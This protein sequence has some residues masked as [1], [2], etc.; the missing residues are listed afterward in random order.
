MFELKWPLEEKL[1]VYV[2]KSFPFFIVDQ[3]NSSTDNVH[4]LHHIFFLYKNNPPTPIFIIRQ[5]I[6]RRHHKKC[7]KTHSTTNILFFVSILVRIRSLFWINSV[8]PCNYQSFYL[9]CWV[10][11]SGWIP[12]SNLCSITRRVC[13]RFFLL[14]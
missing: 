2:L 9:L 14:Q 7:S 6:Q 12:T 13:V 4:F 1:F 5:S 3:L 11:F 8:E 10:E